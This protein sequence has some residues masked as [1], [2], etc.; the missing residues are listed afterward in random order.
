MNLIDKITFYLLC[1]CIL[2]SCFTERID[3][4]LNDGFKKVVISAWLTDL[5]EQ[6]TVL[7]NYSAPYL[8]PTE[9]DYINQADVALEFGDSTIIF[10]HVENGLY[11]APELWRPTAGNEYTLK[12]TVDGK[13]HEA[14]ALMRSMPELEDIR[15][16]QTFETDSIP[17]YEVYFSF[18]ENEGKGDG[19]YGFD[20]IK[21][22][23]KA[24]S[25]SREG[26]MYDDFLDG[27]YFTDVVLTTDG[28]ILGDTVVLDVY[29]IGKDAAQFLE[30]IIAETFKDGIFNP[31]P[32]NIR[33]NF[34]GDAFG[35]FIVSGAKR[36]EVIVE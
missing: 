22:S 21:G 34:S 28:F 20:Y 7:L 26:F 9:I 13:T 25:L 4:D 2:S 6:Q 5:D 33:S 31:P 15:T 18:Q 23:P 27:Y 36:Y 30:D 24:D 35:Y 8:K 1:I 17:L 29:S 3:L 14:T 10:N 32:V 16:L 19:Y 11:E 12:V